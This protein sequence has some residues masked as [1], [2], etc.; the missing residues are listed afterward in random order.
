MPCNFSLRLVFNRKQEDC[1]RLTQPVSRSLSGVQH[2]GFRFRAV[3]A[4]IPLDW[5]CRSI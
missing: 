2:H 1:L 4:W 3:T 5:M